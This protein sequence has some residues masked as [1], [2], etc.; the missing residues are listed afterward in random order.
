M[1]IKDIQEYLSPHMAQVEALIGESLRSDVSLLDA[2]NRRL[3]ETPGKMLRPILAILCG[4]ACG[5]VNADT[6]RFAAASELL[7]NATLLH[8][9][10]VDG[11]Q[12][13]R[14]VPTVA[15]LL[16]G[17]AAVL[18]G[19]FWLTRC[20]KTILDAQQHSELALRIFAETLSHLAEGEILQMQKASSADTTQADYDRII[21]CKTASLFQA[22][23]E[24]AA[25]SVDASPEH[26]EAVKSYARALGMAFQV[27]D[28]IFDYTPASESL[29]KPVGI[30]LTEQ[31]ITQPLLC[32]LESVPGGEAAAVRSAV[33]RL[34]DNPEGASAVRDFVYRNEGVQKAQAV[35]DGHIAHALESLQALPQSR[36]REAL[37]ELARYVGNRDY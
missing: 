11:A 31:K 8:D 28:D 26:L 13:R 35:M 18:I 21:F 16:S 20:M 34:A 9:D 4:E 32:A 12:E 17:S 3:R 6:V 33:S 10:V 15:K 7:H 37:E 36:A 25:L 1:S 2:T 14:G 30:D 24:S 27:K 23:A 19:D 29:G 22:A 5:E